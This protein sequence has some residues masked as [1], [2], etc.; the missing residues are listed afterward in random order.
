MMDADRQLALRDIAAGLGTPV[1]VYDAAVIRAQL[2]SLAR[3]DVVRYAQ[4][5]CS[6]TAIL[7]LLRAAGAV[8]DCVSAGELERALVAGYRPGS[9]P[10]E[11]VYTADILTEAVIARVIELGIPVNA[12]SVCMLE[13][14][15]RRRRGHPVWLRLNPGFGH[16]HSK[17]VSTGGESSKHGIWHADLALAL[18]EVDAYELDLVGIHMHIGSGADFVHLAKVCDAMVEQVMA[19]GRTLRAVSAGGGL[20]IPYRRGEPAVDV[21]RYFALWD[22][23]RRRI[24]D[25]VGS[26]VQLEIEPGRYL[27]G[28]AGVLLAEVR[29]VKQ[30]GR[31]HFTLVDAGFNDL[32]RP[33][34]YGAYHEISVLAREPGQAQG[35]LQPTVVAG[36][37]CESGDVFT[38]LDG[39]HVEPR[40]LPP[41]EIGDYVVFHDV[42][43]YGASMGSNYNSRPLPP[44]VLIDG[45]EVRV[46]RRRQTL[47]ELLRLEREMQPL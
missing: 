43:A 23:A 15:G 45:R 20:P 46:I 37:L 6:N 2:A 39:E 38:Q 16:G 9:E 47:D 14:L 44:E 30:V 29:A 35:E 1:Y 40:A 19:S 7:R 26:A 10:A 34:M 3:F 33:A 25:H 36:P 13:Q 18:A 5:A 41:A 12:G 22:Q 27:V 17:K 11:I 32:V 28:H 8:V 24:E 42:G 4:K 31:N 21:D